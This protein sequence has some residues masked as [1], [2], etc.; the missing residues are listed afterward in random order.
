MARE[1]EVSVVSPV[2]G[3][4]DCLPELVHRIFK[5]FD[6]YE[7]LEVILVCDRSPDESWKVIRELAN[8]DDRI[9]GLLLAKNVGQQHAVTAGLDHATG[10]TTVVLDCDL[11]DSPEDAFGLVQ[12][13]EGGG[14][15]AIAESVFRGDGSLFR[16]TAR[17][18]YFR[19]LDFLDVPSS[20]GRNRTHSFFA[21]STTARL[22]V[23][24]YRERVRQLSIILRDVGF[25]PIYVP[26]EHGARRNGKSSYSTLDRLNLALEGLLLYGSRV[27]KYLVVLSFALFLATVSIAAIFLTRQLLGWSSLPGWFSTIQLLLF[28]ASLQLFGLGITGLYLHSILVEL[29]R[30]PGYVI[31]ETTRIPPT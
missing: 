28:L 22:A 14:H 17:K 13:I 21:L 9:M 25:E 15:I 6:S 12:V 26:V 24:S 19:I 16:T 18:V 7:G 11:Q 29:R 8:N 27:L 5:A 30:R 31:A 2:F 23:C 10:R 20:V 3:C 1:L 4:A